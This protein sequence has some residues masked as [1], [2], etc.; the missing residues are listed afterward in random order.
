MFQ[1]AG[2]FYFSSFYRGKALFD[3]VK[4][5]TLSFIKVADSSERGLLREVCFLN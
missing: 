1:T 2:L 5:I 4:D 3:R